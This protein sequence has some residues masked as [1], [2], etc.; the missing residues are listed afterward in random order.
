MEVQGPAMVR[1]TRSTARKPRLPE[2]SFH[3]AQDE[4]EA[5]LAYARS[6]LKAEAQAL[7]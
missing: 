7:L 1:A 5:T 6:V 3:A 2:P 4:R